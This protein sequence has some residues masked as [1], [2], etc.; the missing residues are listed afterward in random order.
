MT[1]QQ[2]RLITELQ[3]VTFSPGIS[4]K[5][6]VRTCPSTPEAEMSEKMEACLWR[7]AYTYRRQLSDDLAT[8]A[9]RRKKDHCIIPV[10]KDL[11]DKYRMD[12]YCTICRQQ[13]AKRSFNS[14][15]CGPRDRK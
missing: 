2:H 1:E 8:D 7:I 5:R 4:A 10:P 11:P 9:M 12:G 15:C 3:S 14:P 13:F 6:I